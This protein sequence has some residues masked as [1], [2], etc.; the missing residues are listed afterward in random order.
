MVFVWSLYDKN[1]RSYGALKYSHFPTL[2]WPLTLTLK[3]NFIRKNI[4]YFGSK[5]YKTVKF[6]DYS[7]K[8]VEIGFFRL[9]GDLWPLTVILTFDSI[10]RKTID[11]NASSHWSFWFLFGENQL[12]TFWVFEENRKPYVFD[13]MVL[14]F[15]SK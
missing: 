9:S 10:L 4:F 15:D 7:C 13:L 14:T 1:W 8:N 12:K 5:N 3:N 6:K 11:I 2:I